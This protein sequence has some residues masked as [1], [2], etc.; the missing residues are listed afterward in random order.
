MI[1]SFDIM[2]EVARKIGIDVV[3]LTSIIPSDPNVFYFREKGED[4]VFS[5]CR[6]NEGY[7]NVFSATRIDRFDQFQER[8]CLYTENLVKKI[9][10][11]IA[12]RHNV[13]MIFLED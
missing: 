8:I 10:E 2:N 12:G 7:I 4:V 3:I 13:I 11:L 6:F 5:V 9:Q 1:T